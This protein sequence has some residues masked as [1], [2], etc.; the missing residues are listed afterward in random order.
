MRYLLLA[1]ALCVFSS[2]SNAVEEPDYA[3]IRKLGDVEVRFY[4]PYVAA[5]GEPIYARY[6][7]PWTPRF[8]RR[9]EIWLALPD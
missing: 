4:A 1:A 8:M 3:V 7:A 2:V 5:Q 6:N 9:N